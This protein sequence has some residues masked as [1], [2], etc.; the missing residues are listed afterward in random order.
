ML[1]SDFLQWLID[2][3]HWLDSPALRAFGGQPASW[4]EVIGFVLG[5]GSTGYGAV[6]SP[7]CWPFSIANNVVWIP[8]FFTA[9][10]Y[11]DTSL[12]FVYA[13]LGAIGLWHWATGRA[14]ARGKLPVTRTPQ[15]EWH[16]QALLLAV[17]TWWLWA[18][19]VHVHDSAPFLDAFTSVFSIIAMWA[20]VRKYIETWPLWVAI[21]FVYIPL[22]IHKGLMLT[23]ALTVVFLAF[24]VW[25]WAVWHRSLLRDSAEPA[26]PAAVF[27]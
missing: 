22:Y 6:E 10:L 18:V 5:V 15:W 24:A 11:A 27:A 19:L 9:G 26:K 20:Q 17:G 12:Q 14:A 25:G 1:R 2:C 8:L 21:D 16:L 23:A 3:K 13:V 4:A 7:W